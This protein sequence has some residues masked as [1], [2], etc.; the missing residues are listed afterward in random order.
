MLQMTSCGKR[1]IAD[2]GPLCAVFCAQAIIVMHQL[3][4]RA[5]M[6]SNSSQQAWTCLSVCASKH[7]TRLSASVHRG[8]GRGIYRV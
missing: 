7:G 5:M 1:V 4:R 2:A 3:H 6:L 8:F